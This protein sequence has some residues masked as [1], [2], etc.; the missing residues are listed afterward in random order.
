MPNDY[1]W[2]E[3]TPPALIGEEM[4]KAYQTNARRLWVLNVGDIKPGEIG[5]EY[6]LDLAYDY[7]DTAPLTQR[8]WLRRWA[9]R[10]F[11]AEQQDAVASVLMDYYR[12]GYDRKPEHMG[13]GRYELGAQRT[14]FSPVAYGD[15]AARRLADYHDLERRAAAIYAALPADKRDAFYETV[16]YPVRGSMLM[17]EKMLDAD[18]SFL[19]AHQGRASADLYADRSMAAYH[20]T[21]Q[22][23]AAYNAIGDGKWRNFM[24]DEPR[25]Q[26][27]FYGSPVGH[28]IAGATP[29]L[30]VAVEGSVDAWA[31][32]PAQA[33]AD[34]RV[35]VDTWRTKGVDPNRLP[36]FTRSTDRRHFIDVFNTGKGTLAFDV[37]ASAPWIRIDRTPAPLGD[38]SRLWVSIDWTKVPQNGNVTGFITVSGAGASHRIAVSAAND[39]RVPAGTLVEDDGIVAMRADRFV[40]NVA[41]GGHGWQAVSGLGRSG[42]ALE[43]GAAAPSYPVATSAPYAEYRFTTSGSGPV[44]LRTTLVPT[45]PLNGDHKLRYAASIDGAPAQVVDVEAHKDWDDAVQR[46]ATTTATDWPLGR[47]GNH[48]LRV[49]AMDPGLV[50]DSLVVDL[51][52]RQNAYLAPPETVAR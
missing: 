29:G 32:H 21:K 47:P 19:Y 15:E 43:T 48:V 22:A 2:L 17:N 24:D 45:F 30:G 16:L 38:D 14:G 11:G 1:L 20:A 41:V 8:E 5:T 40:R 42:D 33:E 51:G 36:A 31:A 25:E 13:F 3:S 4:G 50:L 9:G 6:F 26:A 12:L 52:G 35:A 44:T 39:A 49:Y 46:N 23:T 37:A 27:V 34:Y 18:R 28:A 10:T 7:G